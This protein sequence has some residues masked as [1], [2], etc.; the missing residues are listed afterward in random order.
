MA[1]LSFSVEYDMSVPVVWY[2]DVTSHSADTLILESSTHRT[3]YTSGNASFTY[4]PGSVLPISG[5]VT[6]IALYENLE[7][8]YQYSNGEFSIAK[9]LSY[10]KTLNSLGLEQYLLSGSD[11]INGSVHND[12]L[13]GWKGNDI[14]QGGGGADILNGGAGVDTIS[15]ASSELSVEVTLN[16]KLPATVSGGD[17]EGE[18]AVNFENVTGS[19]HADTLTGDS[20]ANVLDGGPGADTLT[21]GDGNDTYVIDD[22]GDKILENSSRNSGTDLVYS[23]LTTYTLGETLENL[24]LSGSGNIMGSGNNLKNIIIGNDGNNQLDGG[25]GV[26][27]LIGG[28][29]DDTYLVDLIK[30]GSSAKLED[31]IAEKADQGIDTVQLR[32]S[33][34]L[35]LTKAV[36]LRLGSCLENLDASNT[37]SNRLNLT[38]N[39]L[40]NT[41]VSN[42]ADN[43]LDGGKGADALFGGAGNDTYI[44]D[45]QGD[46]VHEE[47]DGGTDLVKVNINTANGTYQLDNNV[48]NATLI[49]SVA[50][51]LRGNGL[52]NTLIGSSKN[53]IIEGGAGADYLDGGAGNDTVSYAGSSDGVTV[54]LHGNLNAEVSGGDSDDDSDE[55][56][57]SHDVVKNFENVTGSSHIDALF[58]DARNNILDGGGGADQMKG[59]DG[60]D[61]YVVD[62]LGDVVV[63]YAGAKSGK[64]AVISSI[65]YTLR[66]NLE[67]LS[68]TGIGNLDGTGNNLDN[69]INGNEGNNRLDGGG[70]NDTL[71]SGNGDDTINGDAGNDTLMGGDGND[72]LTGGLGG[73][74]FVFDVLPS[75]HNLDHITD[76][77]SSDG[78]RINL[79]HKLFSAAGK[80]GRL[81]AT[82]YATTTENTSSQHILYDS[83]NGNLYYNSDGSGNADLVLIAKL[84]NY[85]DP[86]FSLTYMNIWLI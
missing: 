41:L 47:A 13:Q 6:E 5:K 16:G 35:G 24:T 29:G 9:I 56:V 51:N 50:Y 52:N 22:T 39:S 46:T 15:Y 49:S 38:G 12:N 21:G 53:N 81:S 37:G 45:N 27:T 40:V 36:I 86:N 3:D 23:T 69:I 80:T 66:D 14:I 68:L 20:G 44:V 59:G 85:L 43:I 55:D 77:V 18:I 72:T 8:Q 75:T 7:L 62:D 10:L 33:V 65:S 1:I 78:D 70:G 48:E 63:E 19:A 42:D 4:A 79:S 74:T 11:T 82:E 31:N 26:D 34:D 64:D 54:Y 57:T 58:G 83:V 32:V 17:A 76:F 67:K 30:L 61:S 60:N 2:G 28:K 73:D 84:D 71:N 25:A